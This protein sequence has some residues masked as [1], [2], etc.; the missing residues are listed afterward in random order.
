MQQCSKHASVL[1]DPIDPSSEDR[2]LRTKHY[3]KRKRD[4]KQASGC[5]LRSVCGQIRFGRGFHTNVCACLPGTQVDALT[6]ERQLTVTNE[7]DVRR[8]WKPWVIPARADPCCT[9]PFRPNLRLLS[10]PSP[11]IETVGYAAVTICPYKCD[12]SH[13]HHAITSQ[14]T[15]HSLR[16]SCSLLSRLDGTA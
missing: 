8:R 7:V 4:Y 3:A 11:I 10:R 1:M 6:L 5:A 9:A 2:L 12:N 13:V 16:C 15:Y 14:H